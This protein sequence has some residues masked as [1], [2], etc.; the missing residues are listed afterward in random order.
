MF[1]S[2]STIVPRRLFQTLSRASSSGDGMESAENSRKWERVEGRIEDVKLRHVPRR[3]ESVSS[4]GAT[5][6]YG[7]VIGDPPSR[8]ATAGQ[9]G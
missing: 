1:N 6:L 8:Q 5:P 3:D 7:V 9:V 4:V 2:I